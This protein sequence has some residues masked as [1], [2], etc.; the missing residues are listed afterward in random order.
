M[1]TSEQKNQI[2]SVLRL[3]GAGQNLVLDA[4][5]AARASTD[6]EPLLAILPISAAQGDPAIVAKR[7]A[8]ESLISAVAALPTE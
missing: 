7:A 4:V 5:F 8:L 6:T 1:I 2:L 3:L